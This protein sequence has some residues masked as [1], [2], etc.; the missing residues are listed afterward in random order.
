MI[1]LTILV[2]V[3]ILGLLV[4]VHEFGHFIMA[5]RAGMRVDEF[6]FGFPPRIFGIRKGETLYS[7]NLIPLGGFVKILG[8]DGAETVD[9]ESFSNKTFW[10]RFSV[11]AAGVTM[12]VILAWFLVSIGMTIGLPTVIDEGDQ[13]PKSAVVRNV[14]V[15]ILEVAEQSPAAIAGIKPG[16][17]IVMIASEDRKS[18]V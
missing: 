15:G 4:F 2:F 11:L 6:G 7:I 1:L 18:V 8:E 10:Q 12:N 5:K 16:D 9:P 13:L 17:N 14:T 3:I